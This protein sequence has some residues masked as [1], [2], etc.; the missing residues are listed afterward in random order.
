LF[1]SDEAADTV[2]HPGSQPIPD[3]A[4]GRKPKWPLD[5]PGKFPLLNK[6]AVKQLQE[7]IKVVPRKCLKRHFRRPERSVKSVSLCDEDAN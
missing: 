1:T 2:S 6:V 5:P 3:R 4:E 7:E